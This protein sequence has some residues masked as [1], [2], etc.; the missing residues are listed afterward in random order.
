MLYFYLILLFIIIEKTNLIFIEALHFLVEIEA[1]LDFVQM[2][3]FLS[4]LSSN[5]K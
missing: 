3:C 5:D 2:L 4:Q 1:L